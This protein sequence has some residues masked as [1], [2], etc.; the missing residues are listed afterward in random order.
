M[1]LALLLAAL[2]PAPSS[3]S[4]PTPVVCPPQKLQAARFTPG[5]VLGFRIDVLGADMGTFEI[6]VRPPPPREKRA[7][8]ELTS[9]ARTSAFVSTNVGR[10]EAYA[11]VLL[12]SDFTPL[13]YREDVDEGE[14]H[15]AA[16]LNFP[17]V[18]GILPVQATKNGTPEP[19]T[20][21]AGSDV[22][23]IISTLYLL[24]AQP[25]KPGTPVCMEVYAGR[26]I[27]KL[28]GQVAARETI[29][30]PLGKL[31]SVRLDMESVRV[32]DP[33]VKRTAHIW[34][35]DDER[36]LPLV[37]VGEMRGKVL[38]AQLISMSGTRKRVAQGR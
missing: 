37:A 32:D 1:L 5:E 2:A 25:M 11:A 29:E 26:K 36:R 20:L 15:R 27:W 17:P 16:E 13:H 4:A 24:R 38:R 28:Q 12:A 22:R 9:R 7:A 23:D 6:S 10:Y 21:Q 34:V 31:P 30:T 18:N 3:P 14:T 35:S 8:L 33:R 19:F